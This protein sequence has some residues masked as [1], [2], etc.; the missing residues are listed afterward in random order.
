[1]L[2]DLE[3]NEYIEKLAS[4]TPTP[5]GGSASALVGALASALVNMV[6]N[7]T[8]S[9]EEFQEDEE[10]IREALK[11]A[12]KLHLSLQEYVDGDA[13][14][15][16]KVMDSFRL[17]KDTEKE[18]KLRS[19]TIQNAMVGAADLPLQVAGCCLDVLKLAEVVV[20]KGN[21]NA[22]SDGGVAALLAFAALRGALYNVDINL[23]S[24]KDEELVAKLREKGEEVLDEAASLHDRVTKTV[25]DRLA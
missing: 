4:G 10:E 1:M 8:V 12:K 21:P 6:A 18:K 24:I 5:G 17:P 16:N 20:E 11:S 23:G 22:L 9:K 25:E 3:C 2:I 14:A 15:F 7:L 19:E 13:E